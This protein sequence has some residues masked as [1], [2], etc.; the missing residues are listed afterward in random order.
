MN[1]EFPKT[2]ALTPLRGWE[3]KAGGAFFFLNFCWHLVDL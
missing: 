2:V 1:P 3:G